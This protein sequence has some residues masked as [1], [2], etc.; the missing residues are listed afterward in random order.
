MDSHLAIFEYPRDH[1]VLGF[2]KG[3]QVAQVHMICDS[4]RHVSLKEWLT[5][6]LWLTFHVDPPPTFQGYTQGSTLAAATSCPMGFA[7]KSVSRHENERVPT[8]NWT[9]V[10]QL[11]GIPITIDWWSFQTFLVLDTTCWE[12]MFKVLVLLWLKFN[13]NRES[14]RIFEGT[15]FPN[16]KGSLFAGHQA[17]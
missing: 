2:H 7:A 8:L 3:Y 13:S 11:F 4:T 12:N 1:L 5:H 9:R 14:L 15:G 6:F 16:A 10:T 17:R